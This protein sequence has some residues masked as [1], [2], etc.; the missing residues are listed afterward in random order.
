[1]VEE[2]MNLCAFNNFNVWL[3]EHFNSRD[4]MEASMRYKVGGHKLLPNALFL[5]T[6]EE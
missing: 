5:A 4:A 2:S 6:P 3:R 1:M